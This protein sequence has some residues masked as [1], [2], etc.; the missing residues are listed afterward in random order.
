R[1]RTRA[2]SRRS[3]YS[4]D[5]GIDTAGLSLVG[6]ER[7]L[8]ELREGLR[9]RAP[10]LVIEGPAGIGKSALLEAMTRG[11]AVA[12]TRAAAAA[13][14][15]RVLRA[16]A[17]ELE[18]DLGFGV[19]RRLLGAAVAPAALTG[20]A[21]LAGPALDARPAPASLTFDAPPGAA[22]FAVLHGL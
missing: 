5:W 17:S 18:R 8:V 4:S 14:P 1:P 16:R 7:E 3:Q 2:S 13:P 10:L 9:S 19:I 15:P 22:A 21:A 20:A 11:L 6:R 12:A